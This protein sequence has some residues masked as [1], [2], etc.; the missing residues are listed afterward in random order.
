MK[1]LVIISLLALSF[2]S[3]DN[4]YHKHTNELNRVNTE[5]GLTYAALEY[6]DGSMPVD[7]LLNRLHEL[8]MELNNIR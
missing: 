1:K 8:N 5:I 3:C 4:S 7:S 6:N 2:V